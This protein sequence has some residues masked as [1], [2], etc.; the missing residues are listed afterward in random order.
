MKPVS[1]EMLTL[2]ASR[3][4]YAADLWTIQLVSGLVLCYTSGDQDISAN[5][6]V[7]SAGGQTGPYFDRTGSKAK[8]HWGVGTSVDNLTVEIIPGSATI[9]G[10]PFL[11][12]MREGLFDGATVLLER[13]FMPTYGDTSYGVIRFFVGRVA[14]VVA[15]RS[16]ITMTVNAFTELLNLQFPR[17][18]A[19]TT[20]VNQLGDSVCQ[21]NLSSYQV[22]GL[23]E[24][25]STL[26]A[27]QVGIGSFLPD[28]VFDLGK[29]T[30]TTGILAG[31]S[32]G[33]KDTTLMGGPT[34]AINLIGYVTGLPSPG[35]GVTLTYGCNKSYTDGNGCPKFSNQVHFRGMPFV[36]QPST[37]V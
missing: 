21:V 34:G 4:F 3:Q 27:I 33:I 16:L 12:A 14:E 5:G 37:A 20:C 22:S 8:C 18:V 10:T 36:P 11:Q 32:F 23:V 2:L 30:F 29:I 13:A 6:N 31:Q 24:P 15:G 17:N 35:D 19:Q 26:S 7:Y 1:P 28:G 9:S 25:G